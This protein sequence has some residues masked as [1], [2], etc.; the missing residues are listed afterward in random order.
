MQNAIVK[1]NTTLKYI[2]KK[3][4]SQINTKLR[5]VNEFDIYFEQIYVVEIKR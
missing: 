1:D 3:V 5:H 4:T 2:F